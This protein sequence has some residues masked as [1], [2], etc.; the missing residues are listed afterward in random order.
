L[1]NNALE[2]QFKL[3][4]PN[5]WAGAVVSL[6]F[7]QTTN[8]QNFNAIRIDLSASGVKTVRLEFPSTLD[9]GNDNPQFILTLTP[10]QK[11]YRI[12]ISEFAQNGWGKPVDLLE[13]LKNARAIGI[14][15][16][17][18]GSTGTLKV[19]NVI[20]EQKP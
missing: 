17:T 15:V 2:M 20:L 12:P 9:T 11:T 3:P 10:D 16:D 6:D 14:F 19:D 1:A 7:A 4:T 13:A 18:V 8:L 5:D